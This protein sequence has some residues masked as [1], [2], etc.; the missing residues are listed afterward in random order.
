MGEVVVEDFEVAADD[1]LDGIDV[2]VIGGGDFGFGVA[3]S[4]DGFVNR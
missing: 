1:E 2:A 4:F 3:D